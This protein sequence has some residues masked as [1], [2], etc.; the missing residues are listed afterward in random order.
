M[1][2]HHQH[3]PH[4]P[5][6]DAEHVAKHVR[7]YVAIGV[8]LLLLTLLT[9]GLSYV[10]FGTQQANIVVAM[11]VATLKASLVA[12][13]FMHLASEKWTIYRFLVFTGIA[14]T[15]LFVLTY[16]AFHDPIHY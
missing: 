6:A 5:S 12:A 10:N 11:L 16:C 2:E 7:L 13:V 8:S 14:A 4:S 9:V 15:G 1:S 3:D